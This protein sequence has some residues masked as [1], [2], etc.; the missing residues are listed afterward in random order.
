MNREGAIGLLVIGLLLGG[1]FL[2]SRRSAVSNGKT[3]LFSQEAM[4]W[5]VP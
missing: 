4:V 2:F 5:R 3:D 1:L